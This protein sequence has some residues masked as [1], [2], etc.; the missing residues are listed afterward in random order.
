MTHPYISLVEHERS[1]FRVPVEHF[2]EIIQSKWQF[3]PAL[4]GQQQLFM[5]LKARLGP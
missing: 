1:V 5:S 3:A 2:S 4:D